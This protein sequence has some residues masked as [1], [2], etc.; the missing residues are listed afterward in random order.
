MGRVTTLDTFRDGLTAGQRPIIERLRA[1]ALASAEDVTEQIKWNAP[2][3]GVAGEDRITL[4]L[5]PRG[6]VRV[7]L[8][9]GAKPRDNSDFRFDAPDGLVRWADRDRGVMQFDD[10][11]A[12]DEWQAEVDD[13][14]RRWM[15]QTR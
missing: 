3:F 9:R 10:L 11:A 7:V 8:H 12:L 2:S 15:E 4:G 6:R 5:D 13:V 1:S 14:F